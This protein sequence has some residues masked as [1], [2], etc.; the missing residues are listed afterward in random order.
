MNLLDLLLFVMVAGSVIAGI[1][2]GFTRAAF[3]VIA[4]IVGILLGFWFYDIPAGWYEGW[5][6]KT[7]ANM[8]GFLTVL[9][10]VG[11]IGTILG[12]VVSG[13]FKVVGLGFVDRLAGAGFGLVRGIFAVAAAVAV[14]I[15]ATPR[16]VPSWMRGSAL[17]PY[18]L[19]TSDLISSLA[20]KALKDSVSSSIGEIKDAWNDEM[21]KAKDRAE[22]AFTPAPPPKQEAEAPRIVEAPKLAA[23]APAKSRTRVPKKAPPKAVSQ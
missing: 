21:H 13:A 15:A 16:P 9:F 20:P 1:R 8:F 2:S 14:L 6:G 19:G 11:A 7:V 12:R 18:A 23:K 3:G 17:L 10:M 22:K 5:V 4:T